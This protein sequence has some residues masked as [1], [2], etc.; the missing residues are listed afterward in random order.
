MHAKGRAPR[1]AAS[2]LS[3]LAYCGSFGKD[4]GGEGGRED[5]GRRGMGVRKREKGGEEMAERDRLSWTTKKGR[6]RKRE[7]GGG[8]RRQRKRER[9]SATPTFGDSTFPE[10]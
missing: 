1:D 3:S 5:G 2:F 6:G 9:N 10:D 4:R 7:K 8:G